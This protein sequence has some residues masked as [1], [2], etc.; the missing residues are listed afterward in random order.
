MDQG[1]YILERLVDDA[2]V[3]EVVVREEIDLVE[4]VANIDAA[5]RI[6]L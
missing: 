1:T 3:L 2:R 6:H 5:K 4:E